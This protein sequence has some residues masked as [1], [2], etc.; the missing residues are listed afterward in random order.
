MTHIKCKYILTYCEYCNRHKRV[1]HDEY[2]WCD[3][4]DGCDVCM[5]TKPYWATSVNPTCVYCK[6]AAGALEKTVKSFEYA[7][8]TLHIG[9]NF[10]SDSEVYYLEIDGKVMKEE[11]SES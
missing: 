1:K 6:Y 10:Y 3:G 11:E 4:N 2:W 5:Y 9:R 7:D 8:G